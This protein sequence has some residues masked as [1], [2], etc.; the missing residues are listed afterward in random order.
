MLSAI[1]KLATGTHSSNSS[2]PPVQVALIGLGIAGTIFHTPLVLSLPNLFTLRYVVDIVGDPSSAGQEAFVEKYG[3]NAK[4]TSKFD[5]VLSDPEI[6]M[7]IVASPTYTHF[8]FTKAALEAGKHVLVDKPVTVTYKEAKKL[9]E[10]ARQRNRVLYAFQNRRWDSDYLTLRRILQEGKLGAV[11]DFVSHYDRYR[12][13]LKGTWKERAVPGGG[14]FYSLGPHLIDQTLNAFGRPASVTAFIQ[15]IRGTGDLNVDD[16]FTII[17]HYP[18]TEKNSHLLTATLRGH[19]LSL[20]SPQQRFVVRGS[21]GTFS[22]YG[23]DAQEEQMKKHGHKAFLQNDFAI[24]PSNI[25][26]QLETLDENGQVKSTRVESEKGH[27]QDLY[28]NL[29]AV[30]REGAEPAVKW[31]EAELTMLITELAIRS[32]KEGKTIP[33][34]PD[35]SAASCCSISTRSFTPVTKGKIIPQDALAKWPWLSTLFAKN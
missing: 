16:D 4:F 20:R 27:Y 29:F 22:K 34:P 18:R 5:D 21:K 17:L 2:S 14:Q 23:M 11:T 26:G 13:F 6:G 9:G 25:W 3:P 8:D 28:R 19:L 35:T 7:V 1:N 15:N 32:S 31:E 30:I 24:E 12:D 33:I 10:I